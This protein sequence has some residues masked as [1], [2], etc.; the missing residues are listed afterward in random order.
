LLQGLDEIREIKSRNAQAEVLRKVLL[1][2]LK[3]VRVIIIALANKLD[4][5]QS[6]EVLPREK[7]I[8]ISQE[9]L[10]LYAPLANRLGLDKIRGQLE[11]LA[12]KNLNP[13]KYAEIENF[14]KESSELREKNIIK[15]IELIKRTAQ[16]KIKIVKIKGRP[17]HIYSIYKKMTQRG[18][19]LHEQFDLYGVRIIVPTEKDCYSLLGL[20]HEKFEPV[21]S[22]LKDYIANP[23]P[24]LY[25]SIHTVILSPDGKKIEVQ[26]RTPEMDEFAEEGIAAH[27]KYKKL[28][29]DESFEKRV[30][31]LKEILELQKKEGD[32]EFLE[33][34]KVDV[35]GDT[36]Y[37]YT[38]KGDMKEMPF[39][40]TLLDFAFAVHEQIGVHAVG[41]KING[42]F[43]P[44]R[45]EL[46]NGVVVE[47]LT[48]KNQHPRRSWIKLVKS[49]NSRQK[50]RKYLRMFEKLPD[51]IYKA[52]KQVTSEED[53]SLVDSIDYPTSICVLAKCCNALPGEKIVG[54]VTKRRVV[55]VHKPDCH[56]ALKEEERWI[57]VKWKETFSSKIKFIVRAQE[58]SGFLADLLH[59]IAQAGFE[60]KEAK[61]KPYNNGEM[62]CF[63]AI[64]PRSLDNVK[65]LIKRASKVKGVRKIYFE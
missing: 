37:C 12:F 47:I 25:R 28:K 11:N 43:V 3:D 33:A 36:I 42:K 53:S 23:K 52:P 6:I 61:A 41:G 32:K 15:I 20:L 60:I 65:E 17:K 56:S 54:I 7:Q 44:L 45:T 51:L 34:A 48:N 30:S 35:F 29:S 10:D 19:P 27:W 24:N 58:R 4:N 46:H 40:S 26:I 2:T 8:K 22:R 14:L 49:P 50:I 5:L 63:I 55:S 21:P 13:R 1:T 39:G 59:T 18:V 64:I 57:K 62:E 38:P 16:D 9:V 31:W